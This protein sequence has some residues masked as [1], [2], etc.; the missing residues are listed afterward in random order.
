MQMFRV[1]KS[2]K[3]WSV[4]E[5]QFAISLFYNTPGTFLRNVQKINLPSLS[6]I[7]RW[8]GSSKFSPGFIN[9]Y[10]EQIKIK[11]NAMD[12]EQKYCV[13]AFDEMSIK[14]YLE[15]SKYLDVVEGYEDLGHKGR[16]DKVASQA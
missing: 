9:S 8:I 7:K 5:K 10:M 15:Y 12:N 2:R 14:K 11:V 16:N 6:T 13:I 1:N 3:P 4:E